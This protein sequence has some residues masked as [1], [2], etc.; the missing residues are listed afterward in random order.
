MNIVI[1]LWVQVTLLALGSL[2]M[3]HAFVGEWRSPYPRWY[4]LMLYGS[5]TATG[6]IEMIRILYAGPSVILTLLAYAG[7]VVIWF[8]AFMTAVAEHKL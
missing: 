6:T 8:S 7:H 4:M 1:P 3:G 5:L 2:V